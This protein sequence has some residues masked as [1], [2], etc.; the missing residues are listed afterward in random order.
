MVQAVS[1]CELQVCPNDDL[2]RSRSVSDLN[3]LNDLNIL[4]VFD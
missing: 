1:F 2:N 3:G 4:N